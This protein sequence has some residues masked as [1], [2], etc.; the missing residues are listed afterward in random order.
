MRAIQQIRKSISEDILNYTQVI[1]A[2][3]D[4][5]K[6]R[7]VINTLLKNNDLIRVKKGLYVFGELWR[8]KQISIETLAN[9]IYGP[10]VVSA[11]YVLSKVGL[12]PEH[13]T[14]ITSITSGRTRNFDTPFGKFTYKQIR[15]E[16]VGFGVEVHQSVKGNYFIANPL[17][18]LADKVWFDKRFKP[19]SPKSYEEYLFDDLRIDRDILENYLEIDFLNYL[20]K[21]YE[22]RKITWF[23]QYLKKEFNKNE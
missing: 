20:V 11:D 19:T 1:E 3:H 16:L 8:K 21:A 17:K 7:D 5:K 10:S 13:V 23:I 6:P 9:L 15:K 22:A 4:Y 12:I 18:A 2:L 14:T